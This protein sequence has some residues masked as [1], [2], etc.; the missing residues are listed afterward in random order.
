MEDLTHLPPSYSPSVVA[1]NSSIKLSLGFAILVF[2][3]LGVCVSGML[4]DE[5]QKEE[6]RNEG[7][8]AQEG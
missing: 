2:H 1:S 3:G 7:G 4:K 6:G 5:K 8:E